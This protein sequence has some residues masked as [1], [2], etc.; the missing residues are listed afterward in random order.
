MSQTKAQLVSPVGILT[1]S[2]INV[3]G[4]VTA[5]GIDSIAKTYTIRVNLDIDSV[6]VTDE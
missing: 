2:G 6:S 1:V 4:V 5:S 3:S